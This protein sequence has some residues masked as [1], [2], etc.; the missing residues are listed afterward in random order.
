MA[1]AV[2][3]ASPT[4]WQSVR[5]ALAFPAKDSE[6]LF[7][8]EQ[9]GER[10]LAGV[11]P[12]HIAVMFLTGTSSTFSTAGHDLGHSQAFRLA[13]AMHPLGLGMLPSGVIPHRPEHVV[14]P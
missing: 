10:S 3:S 11:T 9:R 7:V 5:C 2:P 14:V 6:Y 13:I 12:S 1:R 4:H 8:R